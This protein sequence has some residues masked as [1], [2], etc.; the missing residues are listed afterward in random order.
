MLEIVPVS[1]EMGGGVNLLES[2]RLAGNTLQSQP[3]RPSSWGPHS[4]KWTKQ[5]DKLGIPPK[6]RFRTT[7]LLEERGWSNCELP[8]LQSK[9]KTTVVHF[10][11]N[12]ASRRGRGCGR[13]SKSGLGYH[14]LLSAKLSIKAWWT[15]M[16][17]KPI[18]NRKAR[19]SFTMLDSWVIWNERNAWVRLSQQIGS[20]Y[21]PCC[22]HRERHKA[23]GNRGHKA[24]AL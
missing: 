22:Q 1:C 16:S 23:F 4:L 13:W 15:N 5:F 10:F 11:S 7:D 6:N 12:A 17:S 8:P 19:A 24:F 14:P 21:N 20:I 18:P 2:H 9:I 3:T